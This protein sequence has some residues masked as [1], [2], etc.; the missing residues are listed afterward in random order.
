MVDIDDGQLE[1]GNVDASSGQTVE[2]PAKAAPKT[3][4]SI[5][6]FLRII[7]GAKKPE[8]TAPVPQQP[9]VQQQEPVV[10]APTV[11][12]PAP[13]TAP[14]TPS[15]PAAEPYGDALATVV[16]RNR[17]YRDGFR[18]MMR[19]A[20]VEAVIIIAL[21][22]T[23]VSYMYVTQPKDHYFATTADGRIMKLVPLNLPNMS[24]SALMSWVVQSSTEVMTFGYH[25]YQRRLQQSSRHFTRYGWE[26]FTNALQ[27]SRIVESVEALRQVVTAKPRSAPILVQEGVFNGK[28]RWVVDLPL[29]VSYKA[30]ASGRTDNLM[31]RMVIDRVMSLENPNGVG[32]E[33][34]IAVAK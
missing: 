18:N 27:R 25:D 12:A 21:V 4:G 11:A 16:V 15:A 10:T 3:E 23:F 30:A 28:Y 9:E 1:E 26:T 5:M 20:I 13:A 33:Q 31:V 22:L 14:V 7:L 6:K 17:F 19:I 34:W 32:I 29:E 2:A 8:E 24:T